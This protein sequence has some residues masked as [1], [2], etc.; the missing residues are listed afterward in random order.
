[1]AVDEVVEFKAVKVDAEA[2][3]RAD[4][5]AAVT[6]AGLRSGDR[7]G[8]AA[9]PVAVPVAKEAHAKGRTLPA[10]S[11]QKPSTAPTKA[12]SPTSRDKSG[13]L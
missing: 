10:E 5:D 2:E 3:R 6:A 13:E 9:P 12:P 4:V 8:G 11:R 7:L 1:M